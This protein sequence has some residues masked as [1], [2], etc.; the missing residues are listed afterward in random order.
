M[1]RWSAERFFKESTFKSR[2]GPF[3]WLLKLQMEIAKEDHQLVIVECM[4]PKRL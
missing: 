4:F 2:K 1:G 3:F